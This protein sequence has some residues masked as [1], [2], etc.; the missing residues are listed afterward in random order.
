MCGVIILIY[1]VI[2]YVEENKIGIVRTYSHEAYE[3]TYFPDENNKPIMFQAEYDALD[4]INANIKPEYIRDE[5][6]TSKHISIRKKYL[7]N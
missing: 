7:K 3:Y 6:N 2:I 1:L 4:Y 5:C